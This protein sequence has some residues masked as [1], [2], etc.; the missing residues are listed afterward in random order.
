MVVFSIS[1]SCI[2][3]SSN[4]G[5]DSSIAG[6]ISTAG[7]T[8]ESFNLV[9]CA[10]VALVTASCQ[11]PSQVLEFL[12]SLRDGPSLLWQTQKVSLRAPSHLPVSQRVA[13]TERLVAQNLQVPVNLRC[14]QHP[15]LYPH[16]RIWALGSVVRY[17]ASRILR[18]T[19]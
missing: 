14:V 5:R 6:S 17:E 4:P 16:P 15:R 8:G 7:A 1:C 3:T 12:F 11:T 13:E 9:P 19:C 18:L 10:G 2:L